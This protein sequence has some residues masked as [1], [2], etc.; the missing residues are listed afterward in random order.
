M[1]K[2]LL[3]FAAMA[4]LAVGCTPDFERYWESDLNAEL[5]EI[6]GGDVNDDEDGNGNE[7]GEGG[8]Y[9]YFTGK[10]WICQ[11]GEVALLYDFGLTSPNSLILAERVDG[12]F[13]M[14]AYGAYEVEEDSDI[15]GYRCGYINLYVEDDG[16]V[17]VGTDYYAIISETQFA[18]YVESEGGYYP[19]YFDR[20]DEPYN[21]NFG[22]VSKPELKAERNLVF[23]DTSVEATLGEAFTAPTLS[24]ETAGV[25]YSSSNTSVATV[26]STTGVVTLLAAGQ[27]T[28]TASAAETET[29][30]AGT[31][32]Y[33]LTVSAAAPEPV[34]PAS[35]KRVTIAY[36]AS[37]PDGDTIYELVGTI[38]RIVSAYD[39]QNNRISINI[40]DE[41][42]EIQLYRLS[43]VGC[44]DPTLLTVGDEI[45]V[46]GAKGTY[47]N[48]AQMGA[49]GKYI[50][51]IDKDAPAQEAGTYLLEF[52]NK[53]NRTSYSTSSQVWEQNGIKLTNNKASSTADVGDYAAPARFYKNSSLKIE[54]KGMTKIVFYLNSGKPAAGLV[55]STISPAGTTVSADGYVVTV[56]FPAATDVLEIAVLADQIR[57][58]SIKVYAK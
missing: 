51:H 40:K 20:V 8:A 54:K 25:V 31:A 57:V 42:G 17:E 13:Y 33:V 44:D 43:C 50:S 11:V 45:T 7:G 6:G 47:N 27:T 34:D 52:N 2:L 10:Q 55:N 56:V 5:P 12:D 21:I 3:I 38:T 49:G 41:T 32:K 9:D 48:V 18:I 35:P 58:D 4:F 39:P 28:I 53:A 29:L 19:L 23:S 36:F 46:Q 30:Q 22:G 24:G 14:F 37:Q 16:E 15:D 26:N 1:R